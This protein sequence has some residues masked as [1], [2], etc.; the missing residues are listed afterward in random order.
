MLRTTA[1]PSSVVNVRIAS[2]ETT[3]S[4]AP[5]F[6]CVVVQEQP[7][8]GRLQIID[9]LELLR[10]R[11]FRSFQYNCNSPPGE[12]LR[13][14]YQTSMRGCGIH[15]YTANRQSHCPK[16]VQQQT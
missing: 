11:L 15:L 9:D 8:V 12:L 16:P 5:L 7:I 14:T 1:Q 10:D 4:D 13:H 2:V 6:P 3:T